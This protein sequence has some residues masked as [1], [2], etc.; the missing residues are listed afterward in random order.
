LRVV[1]AADSWL[2]QKLATTVVIGGAFIVSLLVGTVL[3]TLGA[4][5]S[6]VHARLQVIHIASCVCGSHNA[7]AR[8]HYQAGIIPRRSVQ[9]VKAAPSRLQLRVE[10]DSRWQ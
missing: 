6:T 3:V 7:K 4:I 8:W 2:H 10:F 9:A 1:I 5:V